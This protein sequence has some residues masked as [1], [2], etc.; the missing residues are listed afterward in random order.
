MHVDIAVQLRDGEINRLYLELGRLYLRVECVYLRLERL[1]LVLRSAQEL[2][3]CGYLALDIVKLILERLL[4]RRRL[5]VYG[6]RERQ[7]RPNK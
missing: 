5:L 3:L 1:V 2:L 6:L 4:S 7:R